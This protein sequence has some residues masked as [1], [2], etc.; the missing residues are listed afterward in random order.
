[1]TDIAHTHEADSRTQSIYEHSIGVSQ[2]AAQFASVFGSQSYAEY[3]GILHDFGKFNPDFQEYILHKKSEKIDHSSVGAI[4]AQEKLK[5]IGTLLAYC[6]AGHHSGLPDYSSENGEGGSLKQRLQKHDL[7]EK[8]RGNPLS[9]TVSVVPPNLGSPGQYN[10][11]TLHMWCRML[12]SCLI[13][14]DWLDTERF[15]NIEQA[16]TRAFHGASIKELQQKFTSYMKGFSTSTGINDIRNEVLQNCLDAAELEPGIY[17]FTA[18]TG[19]GKT[20]SSLGFALK[21]AELWKK[22]RVIFAIP[23]T[24]IIEQTADVYR[25]VLGKENILEH[26]SN[27]ITENLTDQMKMATENWDMPVVVTTNVQLLESCFSAKRSQCRKLHNIAN[28]VIILD[29]AQM[30]PPEFLKPILS[31]FQ[32]LVKNFR[33]T[34]VLC[35]ATQPALIG[36]IGSGQAV[37][38]GLRKEQTKEIIPDVQSL[39]KRMQR[40]SICYDYKNVTDW[41]TL[42]DTLVE[43]QQVLCI[44]NTR[45][46]CQ[47]LYRLMPSGTIHLSATM[48]GAHRSKVIDEIKEK[49][50]NGKTVRVISTQ[51]VEA[52][53]DIDF[54]VVYRAIAGLDSVAQAAGR[55]NREGK[56]KQGKVVLFN[57]C[58]MPPI[59]LQRYG[60]QA[61]KKILRGID[62]FRIEA[63][64]INKYFIEYYAQI[65]CFDKNQI[66]KLLS[67]GSLGHIQFRSAAEKFNLIEDDEQQS[68]IVPYGDCI[69]YL[70]TFE[71]GFFTRN[72][73]RKF[74][75]YTIN[76]PKKMFELLLKTGGCRKILID[77]QNDIEIYVLDP[78]YY[79]EDC[80]FEIINSNTIGEKQ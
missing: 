61:T 10:S 7:L 45:K 24:S 32:C 40:V 28:S 21:H 72:L 74:Q 30:L 22:N 62:E 6:L 34:I 36:E 53:V 25:K 78:C 55:C 66:Q 50:K 71:K 51:V 52:G 14:A 58:T 12:Y 60:A 38:K 5:E 73:L 46:D 23:F 2:L 41:R 9:E 17:T 57:S 80:G 1:M 64:Q 16:K 31:L 29:E 11:N 27:L 47:D 3:C 13:D 68:V 70:K 37:I 77:G 76:V 33:C 65:Q 69:D 26:H 8:A 18:P 42:A 75:R 15:C 44:V 54:P 39:F 4:I 35:S 43:H 59:G 19:V 63:D 67:S 49:L 20:L 48:C 79:S 56:L